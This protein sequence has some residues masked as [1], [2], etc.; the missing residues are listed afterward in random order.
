MTAEEET[1]ALLDALGRGEMPDSGDPAARLLAAL[2]DDVDRRRSF[3][4]M[5]MPSEAGQRR[6]FAPFE[7]DQRR[8]SAPVPPSEVDQRRSS[9]SMTPST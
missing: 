3:E 1:D 7:V 5:T 6:S 2:L 9:V 8:S 4:P